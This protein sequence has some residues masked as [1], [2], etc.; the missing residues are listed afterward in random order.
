MLFEDWTGNGG[1][2]SDFKLA[3]M[4]SNNLCLD[5]WDIRPWLC[6]LSLS[7]SC[8]FPSFPLSPTFQVFLP[9]VNCLDRLVCGWTGWSSLL[10]SRG[11]IVIWSLEVSPGKWQFP[12]YLFSFSRLSHSLSYP[13]CV[14]LLLMM[15]FNEF[16][17][18]LI[19]CRFICRALSISPPSEAFWKFSFLKL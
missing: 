8:F 12:S 9:W 13:L 15:Y 14:S 16:I 4:S 5:L 11:M 7:K 6:M 18:N 17:V 2:I 1:K 19:V 10:L 3:M